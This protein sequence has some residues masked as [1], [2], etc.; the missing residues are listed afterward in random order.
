VILY[1]VAK[2]CAVVI[3]YTPQSQL[4]LSLFKHPFERELDK[5]N[6]WV[7]LTAIIPW[8]A[9]A[10][11]YAKNLQSNS[12]RKSVDLRTVIAAL[13]VK[14][15]LGLDDRGTVAMIQE[16]IYLQYFCGLPGFTTDP[17]FDPS[18][19]VDIGKR[20]GNAAF[21]KFNQRIIEKA[22]ALKPHH[23]RIIKKQKQKKDDENDPAGSS[24]SNKGLLKVDASV[25]DQEITYPTDLKLLNKSRENLERIIDILFDHRLHGNKP[26]DH[27]RVART[28][29]LSVARK[30]R[31]SKKVIRR[32]LKAQLQ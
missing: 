11:E 32:G 21:D 19:F 25:A 5:E 18:L 16:N 3:Q 13:I 31:K 20:L 23:G 14:H 10:E 1:V 28:D 17:V 27:R 2:F 4:S 26:R 24:P 15:K 30:K 9:L 6:R 22:E 8:D 7:K 12:G 29:Y